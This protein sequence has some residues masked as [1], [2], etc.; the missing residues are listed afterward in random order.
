MAIEC[1]SGG[2]GGFCVGR[3]GTL[4]RRGWDVISTPCIV[5]SGGTFIG[6]LKSLT[7]TLVVFEFLCATRKKNGS[8]KRTTIDFA[9]LPDA[10]Y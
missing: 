9:V 4:G 10:A 6:S 3:W 1:G 2:N 8:V 5:D 7:D